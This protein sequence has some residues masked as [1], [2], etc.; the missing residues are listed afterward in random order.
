MKTRLKEQRS[1]QYEEIT[2]YSFA[3]YISD[4][5]GAAGLVLGHGSWSPWTIRTVPRPLIENISMKATK[6][7]LRTELIRGISISWSYREDMPR[8]RGLYHGNSK[9]NYSNRTK[10]GMREVGKGSWK[11][12]ELSN[13]SIFPTTLSNYAYAQKSLFSGEY[14]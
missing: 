7:M 11:E 13:F 5:G 4:L 10:N 12:R 6:S 8:P 9:G 3:E 1:V 2:S 14:F